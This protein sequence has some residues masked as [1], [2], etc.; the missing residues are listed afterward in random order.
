MEMFVLSIFL[1][2]LTIG[3]P[4]PKDKPPPEFP[5]ILGWDANDASTHSFKIPLPLE[6]RVSENFCVPMIYTITCT[7]LYLYSLSGARTLVFRN[8]MAVQV[9][10]L[11]ILVEYKVFNTRLWNSTTFS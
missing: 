1:V 2:D 10:G 5:R 11:A 4:C 6:L 3:N 7:N 8:E 9:S